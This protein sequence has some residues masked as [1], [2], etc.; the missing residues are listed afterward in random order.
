MRGGSKDFLKKMTYSLKDEAKRWWV[1]SSGREHSRQNS[2]S[3]R[4]NAPKKRS[5]EL[6]QGW[7]GWNVEME[8]ETN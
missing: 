7:P 2:S 3:C 5:K 4:V 6:K 8:N 1:D